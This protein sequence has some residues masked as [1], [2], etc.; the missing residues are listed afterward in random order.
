MATEV[1]AR[2]AL[3]QAAAVR[4]GEV[5]SRELVEAALAAIDR[6]NPDINAFVTMA[7]DRALEEARA[8]DRGW[9]RERM[10]E[11]AAQAIR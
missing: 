7:A 2:T 6:L 5:S 8:S 10:L 3:E 9:E 1:L 4:A 11:A